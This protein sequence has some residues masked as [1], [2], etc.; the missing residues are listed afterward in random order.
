MTLTYSGFFNQF[1][2]IVGLAEI[3]V[4][5]IKIPQNIVNE[6]NQPNEKSLLSGTHNLFCVME[7]DI[8]WTSN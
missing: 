1:D 7:T 2:M 5:V 6:K 4:M 3:F 8:L